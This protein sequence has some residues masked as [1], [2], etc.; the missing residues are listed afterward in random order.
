MTQIPATPLRANGVGL[1]AFEQS[2]GRIFDSTAYGVGV[3]VTV[4]SEDGCARR[5]DLFR[6]LQ[7]LSEGRGDVGVETICFDGFRKYL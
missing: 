6:R 4:V 1:S 5:T 2:Y 3:A 7:L